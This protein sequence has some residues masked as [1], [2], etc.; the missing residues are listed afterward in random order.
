MVTTV[1][2]GSKPVSIIIATKKDHA[3]SNNT[4]RKNDIGY[5]KQTGDYSPD[6][7]GKMHH[8]NR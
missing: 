1:N 3:S 7:P 6:L 5:G 4:R 2:E 8:R